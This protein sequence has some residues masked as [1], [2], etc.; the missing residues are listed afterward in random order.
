MRTFQSP[1]HKSPAGVTW[2]VR[3][4][5]GQPSAAVE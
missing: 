2:K 3:A 4:A 1:F 5:P